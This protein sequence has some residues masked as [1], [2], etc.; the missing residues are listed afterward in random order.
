M[1]ANNNT[2]KTYIESY[3]DFYKQQEMLRR[4]GDKFIDTKTGTEV[5]NK[6]D[7]LVATYDFATA[8]TKVYIER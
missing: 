3:F 7:K 6:A 4:R 2:P 5:Y 1:K 8:T